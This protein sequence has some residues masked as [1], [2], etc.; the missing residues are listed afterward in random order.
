[1]KEFRWDE[2]KNKRLKKRRGTSF[3]DLLGSKFI[4]AEK[5][6]SRENQLIL[7]FEYEK[8]I[9]VIPCVREKDYF[10]LKTLFPSR[11]YT[12]KYKRGEEK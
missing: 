8:Y 4:D 12:Q 7:L 10:F 5:H 3:E 2:A 1:M 11:K 9:W 6:P